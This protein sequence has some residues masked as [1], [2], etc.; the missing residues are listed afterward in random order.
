LYID[1]FPGED[2]PVEIRN[3]CILLRHSTVSMMQIRDAMFAIIRHN[4]LMI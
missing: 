4:L 3:V 2:M 1:L